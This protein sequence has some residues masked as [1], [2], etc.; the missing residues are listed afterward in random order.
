MN[1]SLLESKPC[2]VLFQELIALPADVFGPVDFFAFF[3]LAS[4][5]RGEDPFDGIAR[6]CVDSTVV[7]STLIGSAGGDS[8]KASSFPAG[9]NRIFF[10]LSSIIETSSPPHVVLFAGLINFEILNSNFDPANLSFSLRL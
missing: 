4:S 1:G 5:F 7:S 8:D 6:V 9:G 2:R 3:R 10:G